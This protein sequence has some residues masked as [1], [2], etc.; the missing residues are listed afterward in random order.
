MA[1]HYYY[2]GSATVTIHQGSTTRSVTVSVAAGS[3]AYVTF[4]TPGGILVTVSG[5]VPQAYATVGS[6][7]S[8]SVNVA[9]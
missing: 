7:V 5:L 1:F 2:G 3:T 6:L 4:A 8:N 9:L